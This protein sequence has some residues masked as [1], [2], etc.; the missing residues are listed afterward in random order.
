MLDFCGT[1]NITADIEVIPIQKVNEAYERHQSTQVNA[2]FGITD[3]NPGK[4]RLE[5]GLG[6]TLFHLME[7]FTIDLEDL[8]EQIV[9]NI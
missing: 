5:G 9:F 3:I 7:L 2:V 1:H 4:M 8:D 6:R